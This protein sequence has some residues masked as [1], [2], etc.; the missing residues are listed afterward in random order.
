[1]TPQ[2]APRHGKPDF[3]GFGRPSKPKLDPPQAASFRLSDDATRRHWPPEEGWRLHG[4][5]VEGTGPCSALVEVVEG[6]ERNRQIGWVSFDL[7]DEPVDVVVAFRFS[8]HEESSHQ[9]PGREVGNLV[10]DRLTSDGIVE[11]ASFDIPNHLA[12]SDPSSLPLGWSRWSF[13]GRVPTT[14][15]VDVATWSWNGE[16]SE[17]IA[18]SARDLPWQ[19][20]K[21][22]ACGAAVER[23]QAVPLA[24]WPEPVWFLRVAIRRRAI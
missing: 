23:L 18:A 22:H 9:F 6:R 8:G 20:L 2:E 12:P 17:S 4:I 5:R 19:S 13:D 16:G 14:T 15:W 10:F 24:K 7:D 3:G 1:V 21:L 11:L